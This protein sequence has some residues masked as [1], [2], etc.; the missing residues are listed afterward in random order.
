[1]TWPGSG[2]AFDAGG[3]A[4]TLRFE[5]SGRARVRVEAGNT[6]EII[7]LESGMSVHEVERTGGG[8][9]RVRRLTGLQTSDVTLTRIDADGGIRPAATRDRSMLIIG[10]SISVGYGVDGADQNCGYSV[11][12]E[13]HGRT[14]GALTADAL[15]AALTTVAISGRGVVRN[16][17]GADEPLMPDVWA[18]ARD[19]IDAAPDVVLVNLGTNDFGGYDPRPAFGAAYAALLDDLRAAYPGAAIYATTG[20]MLSPES[21]ALLDESVTAALARHNGAAELQAGYIAFSLAAEGRLYG[22]HWHPGRDT[23]AAM[24]QILIDRL[25]ADLGWSA[26]D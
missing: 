2:A 7:T 10:D 6:E 12:T 26:G 15:G 19:G 18:E 5:S 17:A 8:A 14:Y 3:A 9:V 16:W 25:A 20:P 11:E 13:N 4:L 23:Q 1:L 24:A 22:C 21:R